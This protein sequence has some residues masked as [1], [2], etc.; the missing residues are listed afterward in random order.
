MS[1]RSDLALRA[2]P[3]AGSE[4]LDAVGMLCDAARLTVAPSRLELDRGVLGAA[5]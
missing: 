2:L 5:T 4:H 1:L 3:L